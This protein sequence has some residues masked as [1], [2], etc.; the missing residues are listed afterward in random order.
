MVSCSFDFIKHNDE[1]QTLDEKI[2]YFE[3]SGSGQ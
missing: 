3:E 2:V 1:R